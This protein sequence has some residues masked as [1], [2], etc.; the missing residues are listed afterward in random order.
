MGFEPVLANIELSVMWPKA[1]LA[2]DMARRVVSRR[3]LMFSEFLL[4]VVVVG[5]GPA[6][7]QMNAP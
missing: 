2:Q 7:H 1:Q 4:P 6:S 3:V 5:Q